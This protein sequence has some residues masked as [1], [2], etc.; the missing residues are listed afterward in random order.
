ELVRLHRTLATVDLHR[1]ARVA[2]QAHDVVY[3]DIDGGHVAQHV[4]RVAAFGA[5]HVANDIRI[6]I[7]SEL[8]VLPLPGDRDGLQRERRGRERDR[9]EVDAGRADVQ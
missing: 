3:V 4:Q 7:R 1:H 2:A 6:T 5:R 8:Y 9:S